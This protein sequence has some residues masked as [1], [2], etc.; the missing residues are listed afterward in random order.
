MLYIYNDQHHVRS[1]QLGAKTYITSPQDPRA[2]SYKPP[3]M[4]F[5]RLSKV[6]GLSSF[7]TEIALISAAVRKSKSTLSIADAMG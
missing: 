6:V 5:I 7:L 2:G 1:F 4:G 3:G